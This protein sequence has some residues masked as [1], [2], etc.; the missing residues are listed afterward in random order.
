MNDV[1]DD[2]KNR[3]INDNNDNKCRNYRNNNHNESND[4]SKM[5]ILTTSVIAVAIATTTMTGSIITM[6]IKSIEILVTWTLT[7]TKKSKQ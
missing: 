4:S 5:K 6:A 2:R 3:I 1:S 7:T